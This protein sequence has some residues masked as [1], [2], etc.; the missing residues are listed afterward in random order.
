MSFWEAMVICN[1]HIIMSYIHIY[2]HKYIY[3]YIYIYNVP[4]KYMSFMVKIESDWRISWHDLAPGFCWPGAV[5]HQAPG[6][7][8]CGG[9]WGPS[10]STGVW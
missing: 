5:V 2:V 6:G 9:P 7:R 1:H 3:R 10:G 8:C 4:Y